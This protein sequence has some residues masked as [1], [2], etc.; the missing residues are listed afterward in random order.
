MWVFTSDGFFSVVRFEHFL[1]SRDLVM[2]SQQED[3]LIVRGRVADDLRPLSE[4]TDRPLLATSASD[5]PFRVLTTKGQWA[6]YLRRAVEAID[7]PNFKERV[8]ETQGPARHDAYASVWAS[9]T[10]LQQDAQTE[11]TGCGGILNPWG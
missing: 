5:Y 7:Y 3:E 9:L 8:H 10:T 2:K 1:A 11:D 4:E 6:D